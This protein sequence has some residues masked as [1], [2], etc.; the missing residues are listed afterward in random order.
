MLKEV[1]KYL[2]DLLLI[3]ITL[4]AT[5]LFNNDD[6]ILKHLNLLWQHIKLFPNDNEKVKINKV[7]HEIH[8]EMLS[9]GIFQVLIFLC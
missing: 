3:F 7:I 9:G 5:F 4:D 6:K 1:F 8:D 2:E